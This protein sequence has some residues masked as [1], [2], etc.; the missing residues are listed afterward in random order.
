MDVL[1]E[2]GTD[3]NILVFLNYGA[4]GLLLL[5]LISGRLRHDREVTDRD[6]VIERQQA[7]LDSLIDV[8][9][10]DVIPTL[11]RTGELLAQF[12]RRREES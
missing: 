3:S 9:Q 4:A 12:K 5:L 8:Y 1:A 10:R 6:R 11:I 7:Q 2:V